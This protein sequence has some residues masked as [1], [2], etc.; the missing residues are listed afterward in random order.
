M[1]QEDL[2]AKITDNDKRIGEKDCQ[3]L[4]QS[5][6]SINANVKLRQRTIMSIFTD[7]L[8]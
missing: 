4:L 6:M 8:V 1:S 2:L 7:F 3:I 5:G